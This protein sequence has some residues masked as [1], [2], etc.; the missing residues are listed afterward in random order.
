MTDGYFLLILTSRTKIVTIVRRDYDSILYVQN[1]IDRFCVNRYNELNVKANALEPRKRRSRVQKYK[2]E[3]KVHIDCVAFYRVL[4]Y[5]L[6]THFNGH[7]RS[8]FNF[9]VTLE[10]D[11]VTLEVDVVL[12]KL[13]VLRCAFRGSCALFTCYMKII[14]YVWVKKIT[15]IQVPIVTA[16]FNLADLVKTCTF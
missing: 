2:H 14:L 15:M 10:V 8:C 7:W 11:V 9:H 16:M 1:N 4:L 3:V 5:F 6:E 13:T 12:L